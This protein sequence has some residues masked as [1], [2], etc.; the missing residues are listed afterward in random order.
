M[1]AKLCPIIPILVLLVTPGFCL[2]GNLG[3]ARTLA[4]STS[5]DECKTCIATSG[6]RWCAQTGSTQDDGQCCSEA[7]TLGYCDGSG[8]YVCSNSIE[9]IGGLILCPEVNSQC[10]DTEHLYDKNNVGYTFSYG[11]IPTTALCTERLYTSNFDVEKASFIFNNL[12][13]L[14]V[15]LFTA[16]RGSNSY[17][18]RGTGVIGNEISVPFSTNTDVFM[19]TE[20]L[21]AD[22]SYSISLIISSWDT[23]LDITANPVGNNT[24]IPPKEDTNKP[25]PLPWLILAA[26]GLLV[27]TAVAVV[28]VI[29]LLRRAKRARIKAIQTERDPRN[30]ESAFQNIYFSPLSQIPNQQINI[31]NSNAQINPAPSI[32]NVG[33]PSPQIA[34]SEL[35]HLQQRLP[36][37]RDTSKIERSGIENN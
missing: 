34:L 20:P 22:N 33:A 29:C 30:P 37:I 7:D 5:Q 6:Q 8:S 17:D 12:T 25:S 21:S 13:G 35:G 16:P 1:A 27:I 32:I 36:P 19:I 18:Y 11:N 31:N 23:S 15:I 26:L 14:R 9:N 10:G 4:V 2:A 3:A 28:T 24:I